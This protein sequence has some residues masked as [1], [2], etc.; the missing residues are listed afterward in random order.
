MSTFLL[1]ANTKYVFM[2][3]IMLIEI[4]NGLLVWIDFLNGF[5]TLNAIAVTTY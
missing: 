4:T 1:G 2:S 3:K 5:A